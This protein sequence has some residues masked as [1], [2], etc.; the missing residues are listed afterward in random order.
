MQR[1]VEGRETGADSG[2]GLDSSGGVSLFAYSV[3]FGLFFF[4]FLLLFLGS[5]VV[6]FLYFLGMRGGRARSGE[7]GND[8]AVG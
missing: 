2:V 8:I 4:F 6:L 5:F 3:V 1:S 7:R